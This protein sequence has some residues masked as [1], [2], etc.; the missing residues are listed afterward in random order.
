VTYYDSPSR[1]IGSFDRSISLVF[2]ETDQTM[3]LDDITPLSLE[4]YLNLGM[5]KTFSFLQQVDEDSNENWTYPNGA[6]WITVDGGIRYH[7]S[8]IMTNISAV[9]LPVSAWL[10]VSGLVGLVGLA[11]RK[12]Y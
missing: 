12:K 7:G 6:E 8:A 1:Y 3:T 9:P 5:G 4:D 10:F 2:R 11:R